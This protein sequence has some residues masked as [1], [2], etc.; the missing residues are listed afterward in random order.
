MP[1]DI[2]ALEFCLNNEESIDGIEVHSINFTNILFLREVKKF[3]KSI[4]LGVGGRTLEEIVFVYNYLQKQNLVFLYGF[5]SFPTNFYKLKM[6]K[7]DKLREIFDVEVGYAD[8]TSFE[9]VMRYNLI[10]YA[11]LNGSRIFEMHIVIDEGTKRIDYNSAINSITFLKI[12]ERLERL[13][14]IQ[15]YEFFYTLNNPE[16]EYKKR[17]KKIVAKRDIEKGEIFSEDNVWLKV[18]EESSD[19][20]Q[21]MYNR[22]I[23]KIALRKIKQDRTINFSDVN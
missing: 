13:I 12:R 19:F 15:G 4:I 10:E 17:E 22:I 8:H 11:Y 5:Q 9:D 23:G 7:I 3:S 18:S 1:I 21:I 16:E 14:K 20:E 2:K 6:F